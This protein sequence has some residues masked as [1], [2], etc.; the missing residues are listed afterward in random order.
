MKIQLLSDIHEEIY[1]YQPEALNVDLVVL[2]GDI[3]IKA[4]GVKWA[5]DTFGC[6]VLYVPGNH[7]YY[8]GHLDK[9]LAKMR[10]EAAKTDGRVTILERD[11]VVIDGVRFLGATAWTDFSSGGNRV[12]AA[13]DAEAVMS[14]YKKIRATTKYRKL[15][16]ADLIRINEATRD[17]LR[18][19]LA[20]P[21]E[22]K[23]VVVTH[24]APTWLSI[25][26][27]RVQS[28][29]QLNPA[30]ANA[31]EYEEFFDGEKVQFWLHGHI[32]NAADYEVN[33][34]RVICNPRG[35][36]DRHGGQSLVNEFNPWLVLDV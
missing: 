6:R 4:H 15:R 8:G 7:E 36:C 23:T 28:K 26:Q 13:F 22:G 14:D 19:E 27:W 18:R 31:W 9:T 32:H 17:W 20:Q 21:F 33:G 34:V 30:Y 24:H 10:E 29:D 35:Y 3:H 1:P 25:P 16:P 5:A 11:S 12:F 2:A